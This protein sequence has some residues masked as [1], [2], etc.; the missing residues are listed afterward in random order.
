MKTNERRGCLKRASYDAY[1]QMCDTRV[2]AAMQRDGASVKRL[3]FLTVCRR[4]SGLFWGKS[5][6][7]AKEP[8]VRLH[9]LFRRKRA[10]FQQA[11]GPRNAPI[12]APKTFWR[13]Q[14]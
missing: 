1:P 13:W 4:K 2:V 6:F 14:A 11:Q 9:Y 7:A 12:A 8:G 3:V 10:L 5:R